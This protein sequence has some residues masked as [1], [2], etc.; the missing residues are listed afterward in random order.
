MSIIMANSILLKL[1]SKITLS[2]K[3]RLIQSSKKLTQ[4]HLCGNFETKR[5]NY[6][7]NSKNW[8]IVDCDKKLT[9]WVKGFVRN[10]GT[11]VNKQIRL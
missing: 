6:K 8:F 1:L 11:L 2:I 4:K 7:I 3:W 5:G 9:F 10:E